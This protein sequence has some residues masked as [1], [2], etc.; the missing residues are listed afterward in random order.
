M[1][2]LLS[3]KHRAEE[4]FQSRRLPYYYER[5]RVVWIVI[6]LNMNLISYADH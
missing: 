1:R 4:S 6:T 3:R 5:G 2:E